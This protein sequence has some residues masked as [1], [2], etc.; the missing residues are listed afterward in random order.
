M[1]QMQENNYH[2]QAATLQAEA[3]PAP[4][5]GDGHPDLPRPFLDRLAYNIFMREN[6]S[7]G[8]LLSQQVIVP[9]VVTAGEK[10][11]ERERE[12]KVCCGHSKTKYQL[13]PQRAENSH[14]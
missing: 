1:Q 3:L 10:E 4:A 13:W 6:G 12:L 2:Q 9:M 5:C 11:R 8:F 7:G 14:N